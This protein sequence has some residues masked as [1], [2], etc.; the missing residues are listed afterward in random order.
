M[1][2]MNATRSI[3]QSFV[4]TI[5]RLLTI[6]LT[7]C[8]F[9]V[10]GALVVGGRDLLAQRAAAEASENAPLAAP[11]LSVEVAPL[12]IT[13]GYTVD[14]RFS[15]QLEP[16]QESVMGFELPGT[17][18][19]ILVDEGEMVAEGTLLARLDTRLIDA[20][21]RGLEASRKA[22]EAQAELARRT[23][24]RQ[25]TLQARGFASSQALDNAALSLAEL[26]AR[27]A[28]IDAGI[29]RVDIRKEKSELRAPFA[30]QATMRYVDTGASV[31]A[32]SP[33]VTLVETARPQFRVGLS[34]QL[35]AHLPEEGAMVHFGG[36]SHQVAL[37]SVL[38][39]LDPATRT[40]TALFDV[41]GDDHP[42]F[43]ETGVMTLTELVPAVGAMVPLS[44]LQEGP[45]GLWQ[46]MT[47]EGSAPSESVSPEAV[48]LLFTDGAR[49]YVRG[50]FQ[51]GARYVVDGLH[52]LVPGQRV[53]SQEG[54]S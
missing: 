38:P 43:G 46:I 31:N 24:E 10:A 53:V 44:A 42:A 28:E 15:G 12:V 29:L 47:V 5:R 20:E 48:E 4:A 13:D 52:R 14:R 1:A 34:P 33:V 40:R 36:K 51:D 9:A 27:L 50:T 19:Q 25:T 32:G 49:A 21:R 16:A 23:T 7:L 22:L 3:R 45:R 35:L 41:L 18:A 17:V 2:D 39:Q 37:S 30:G 54:I 26:E 11:A 6:A 8:V